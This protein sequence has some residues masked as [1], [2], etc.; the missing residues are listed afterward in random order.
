MVSGLVA[1]PGPG[2]AYEGLGSSWD[3]ALHFWEKWGPRGL[4]GPR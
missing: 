2:C 4:S 1:E 3:V